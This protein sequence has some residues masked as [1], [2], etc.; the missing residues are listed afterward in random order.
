MNVSWL[1]NKAVVW[2]LGVVMA[3][4]VINHLSKYPN[5]YGLDQS[6]IGQIEQQQR[7]DDYPPRFFRMANILERRNESRIFYKLEDNFFKIFDD[8][9]W[10]IWLVPLV[11]IGGF[12]LIY[13]KEYSLIGLTLGLPVLVAIYSGQNGFCFYPFILISSMYG[14]ATLSKK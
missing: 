5:W 2:G 13:Q 8:H 6:Q 4:L 11:V 7:M 1:K 14:L 9:L 10:S 12:E 3:G